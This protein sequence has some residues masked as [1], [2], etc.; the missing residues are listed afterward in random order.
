M[1]RGSKRSEDDVTRF[2]DFLGVGVVIAAFW[3][4]VI[5][6][7]AQTAT[8]RPPAA[9]AAVQRAPA[10]KFAAKRLPWGDPDISGNFTTKDEA[11]TPLERPE[12]FAGRRVEDITPQEM[13]EVRAARQQA[14]VENAPFLGQGNRTL[15]IAIGVPIHW[16]DHLDAENSRPWLV[17]DPPDGKIPPFSDEGRKRIDAMT[18]YLATAPTANTINDRGPDDRC[19]AWGIGPARTL[20][21]VYGMSQQILQTKDYVAIRYEMIHETRIIPIAGRGAARP[22][23]SDK[24]RSYY[25][26]S[27]GRWEGDTFVVEGTNYKAITDGPIGDQLPF[28]GA[29]E[30]LRT[31]ERF[32]R[33]AANKV[34]V[35]TTMED[36]AT[37]SRP[38]TF[39]MPWTEDDAQMIFEYACHEGNYGVRNILAGAR[40]DQ[41]KGI[42]PSNG[43]AVPSEF[44]Q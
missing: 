28:R 20:P 22:H 9:V 1:R 11:N 41:K 23:L 18:S 6:G 34:E 21:S 14:A 5:V 39:A 43:A 44:K 29:S 7:Q 30:G 4:A 12:Q 15:G 26:D 19:I 24:L 42:E 16:L 3:L 35:T 25:G 13:A 27:V 38:W 40:E 36:G 37:W 8:S 32:R 33:V 10:A 2:V 17:V 31:I